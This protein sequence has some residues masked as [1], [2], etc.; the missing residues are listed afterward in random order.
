MLLMF[1]ARLPMTAMG[2]TLTLYVVQNLGRGYGEAGLVG[3]ATM[4]GS[5]LGSPLVGRMIDRFGLR[6]IVAVCGVAST[7]FWIGA[8]H[9]S[10]TALLLVA[11]PGGL[12]AIPSG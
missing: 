7:A 8:P 1:F 3:T 6:P 12:L 9:L 2:V 4:L 10:Y 11:L 5:A